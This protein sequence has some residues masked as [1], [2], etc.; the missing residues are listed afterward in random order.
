MRAQ[1][2]VGSGCCEVSGFV[3]M[4]SCYP[5]RYRYLKVRNEALRWRA[6]SE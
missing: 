6:L 5:V 4:G 2:L 1:P 3:E